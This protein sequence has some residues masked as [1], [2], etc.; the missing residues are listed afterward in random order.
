M[1]AIDADNLG[2]SATMG[3][4]AALGVYQ[5]PGNNGWQIMLATVPEESHRAMIA[6]QS[7]VV[8]HGWHMQ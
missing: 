1:I 3:I 6:G 5:I 4:L 2:S 7:I 8:S